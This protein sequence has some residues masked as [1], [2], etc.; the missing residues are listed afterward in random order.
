MKA[1]KTAKGQSFFDVL[2]KVVVV[3]VLGVLVFL[4]L[5]AKEEIVYVDSLKLLSRYKGMDAARVALDEKSKTWKMN[6]DTLKSELQADIV[7][8]EKSKAPA[9]SSEYK[10]LQQAAQAKQQQL[11]SYQES[12][13]EQLQKEDQELSADVLAKVNDYIRRYSEKKGYALVIVAVNGNVAYGHESKD[14]TEDVL[15]GLNA[16]YGGR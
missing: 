2:F 9:T 1:S 10:L 8:L 12:V 4:Q 16:E 14:V 13:K 7:A 15:V 11:L 3:I 5:R 6:L